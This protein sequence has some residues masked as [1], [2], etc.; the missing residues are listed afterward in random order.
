MGGWLAVGDHG[1][2]PVAAVL[3]QQRASNLEAVLHVGRPHLV[4][5]RVPISP[6]LAAA[7]K[8][9]EARQRPEATCP[10]L[11]VNRRGRPY[12]RLWMDDVMDRLQKRVG[13]RVHARGFRH[14][15]ATVATKLG[16]NLE[17]LRTAMG[18][19]DYKVL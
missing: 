10:S 17:H 12:D 18:Y 8:R 16:W 15:F 2:L 9:Y 14:T 5:Q 4:V 11:L 7:I 13:V 6:K 19:A 3:G 1:H